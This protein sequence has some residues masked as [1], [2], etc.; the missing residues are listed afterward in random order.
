MCCGFLRAKPIMA[1][2][3]FKR[4]L[5]LAFPTASTWIRTWITNC[6]RTTSGTDEGPAAKLSVQ[7]MHS[8]FTVQQYA[9]LVTGAATQDQI[10]GTGMQW[11]AKRSFKEGGLRILWAACGTG[12]V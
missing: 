7:C 2:G 11:A 9:P 1:E 6:S 4:S 12:V 8:N 5:R 3:C 10:F